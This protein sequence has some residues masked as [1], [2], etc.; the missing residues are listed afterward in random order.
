MAYTMKACVVG[1][2][3]IDALGNKP[4]DNFI[5]LID[6]KDYTSNIEYTQYTKTS[7][8]CSIDSY[9][10]ES[11]L[12]LSNTMRMGTYATSEALFMANIPASSNVAVVLSSITGGNDLR[13]QILE[14]IKNNKKLF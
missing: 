6:S 10:K 9:P 8:V 11:N 5:R 13:W 1:Y 4:R 14:D 7:K 12:F 3:I 2:G